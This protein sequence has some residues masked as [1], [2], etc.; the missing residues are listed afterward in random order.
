MDK[1]T[2]YV[3]MLPFQVGET[4]CFSCR[5]NDRSCRFNDRIEC[6]LFGGSTYG[7]T[8]RTKTCREQIDKLPEGS[9]IDLTKGGK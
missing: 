7:G 5:F 1:T 2:N 8:L 6:L 3:A 4:T 9:I